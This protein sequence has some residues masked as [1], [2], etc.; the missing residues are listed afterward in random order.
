MLFS[1]LPAVD[2]ETDA[3]IQQTIRR[4]FVGVT[5]LTIAHRIQTILDYDRIMVLEQVRANS[6]RL[7]VEIV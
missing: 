6:L 4:A 1:L 3:L 2:F 7:I 5:V